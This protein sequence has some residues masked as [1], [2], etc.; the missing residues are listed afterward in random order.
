MKG[1]SHRSID[2]YL[3]RGSTEHATL[4]LGLAGPFANVTFAYQDQGR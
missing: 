2:L 4:M 3:G 1:S